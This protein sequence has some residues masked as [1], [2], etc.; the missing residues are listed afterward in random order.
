MAQRREFPRHARCLEA[1]FIEVGE[2]AAHV[3]GGR[4]RERRAL[5]RE[6]GG[7]I[8]EV[9]PVGVGGVVAGALFRRQHVEKQ[10]GELRVS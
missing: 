6:K 1:T 10:R 5:A 2:I 4:A 9:A 7:E 8:V 3:V